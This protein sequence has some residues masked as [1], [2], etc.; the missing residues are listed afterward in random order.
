MVGGLGQRTQ[1]LILHA[2]FVEDKGR[3]PWLRGIYTSLGTL[4]KGNLWEKI[5]KY[6]PIDLVGADFNIEDYI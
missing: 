5:Y 6:I 4:R 3:I 2:N 1:W